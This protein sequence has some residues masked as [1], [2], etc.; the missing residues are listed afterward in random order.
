MDYSELDN[1]GIPDEMH[2]FD[3]TGSILDEPAGQSR[4]VW[5]SANTGKDAVF[6]LQIQNAT[7]GVQKAEM[8]GAANSIVDI[9]NTAYYG[10]G[11]DAYKPF[12]TKQMLALIGQ[13]ATT[14]EASEEAIQP[15][16]MVIWDDSNGNL[17]YIAS[18]GSFF[19]LSQWATFFTSQAPLT[20]AT[21]GVTLIISC[22]QRPYK[23]LMADLRDLVLHVRM[24]RIRYSNLD[25]I[26]F[27]L[28]YSRP[29]SFG[30]ADSNTNEVLTYQSPQNQLNNVVDVP[31]QFYVDK[32]TSVYTDVA[33]N[34]GSAY[35]QTTYNF[36]VNAYRNNGLVA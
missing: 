6:S 3:P 9:P 4:G 16:A 32:L 8:F 29:K 30:G 26:D 12:T 19:P 22:L 21:A 25:G 15:P 5:D 2:N 13:V 14:A 34:G 7:S 28:S 24:M 23:A 35:S 31:T 27:P 18:A 33:D 17:V 20:V 36:W 10:G 1:F 11:V